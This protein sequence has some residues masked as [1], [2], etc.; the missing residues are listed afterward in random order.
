MKFVLLAA[1]LG[2][3]ASAYAL[4]GQPGIH[5]PSTVIACDGKFYVWGTG[6][7]GLVSDDGW[8]WARGTALGRGGLAPDIIHIGGQYFAFI[9]ANV[10]GEPAA[11]V[12][13]MSNKTLDPSSPDFKWVQGG[14][15]AS[16][17]GVEDCNAIDPGVF[18]DPTTGRLWLTYGSYIGYIRLV[19][20]DP[21]TGKRLHP[22]DKPLD[23]AV[24]CEA[25]DMIYHDGWYY[26]L[27]THGSCC[28]GANSGYHIVMGRSR[29]VSG[30]FIDV[31]RFRGTGGGSRALRI[32][33]F[34]RRRPEILLS[35]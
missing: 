30:P 2:F 35:L 20:L 3:A 34:G 7:G 29:S 13:T 16:S 10:G 4:D 15:V 11:E 17:D 23:L 21:S 31:L 24:N 25:S 14:V 28:S 5:D 1:V 8:A 9:A 26:L 19:E 12:Y 32:A 6:G 22:G 18:L 27:A 33:G